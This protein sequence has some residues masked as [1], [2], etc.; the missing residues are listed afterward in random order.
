MSRSCTLGLA[1][2]AGVVVLAYGNSL[3]GS[4]HYDDFH[5][6]A[7]NPHIRCL[8]NLPGFFA[9]PGMFSADP[10]KAMYRPLL[11]V[12]YAFNYAFNKQLGLDGYDV[13]SFH[14][15]NVGLHLLGAVLVWQLGRQTGAGDRGALLAGLLF[16]LHPLATEPVNYLSSRSESLGAVL[17]LAGFLGFVRR[18][19]GNGVDWPRYALGLLAFAG[20]LLSKSVGIVLPLMLLLYEGLLAGPRKCRGPGMILKLHGPF[21]LV[22]LAYLVTV[23]NF[24]A[25]AGW[26][27]PVRSLDV[28]LWTQLKAAVYYLKLGLVPVGL[29]VEHQFFEAAAFWQVPVLASGLVLASLVATGWGGISR[30]DG[31]WLAWVVVTLAPSS[32]IPLNVLVNEHRLYL[33]MAGLAVAAGAR[34]ASVER[35]NRMKGAV[36][37][38]LLALGILTWQR[39]RVWQDELS[40]WQDAVAKGPL[41]P[42]AHVH[43]GNARRQG[44]QPGAARAA[45]ET[46]LQLEPDHRAARTNLGNLYY[47]A[48]VKSRA[49]TSQSRDHLL[50]AAAHYEQVLAVDSTYKEALNNLGSVYLLLG[51]EEAAVRVYRRA[52]AAYPH[53]GTAYFNL[54]QLRARQGVPTE[55]IAL[56]R[57]ALELQPD[58]ETC[59]ELGNVYAGQGELARAATA[60]RQ[61]GQLDRGNPGYLYNL[62]EVL[63]VLGEQ[64]LASGDRPRG[65]GMWEEAR[66]CFRQVAILAPGY[67]RVELRLAQLEER[68]P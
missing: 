21:W 45:F 6:M 24:L 38:L 51:R 15:V 23:W 36:L 40:L 47:E 58:A 43:L 68:L 26:G 56:Y 61:A 3:Q 29:N 14:L 65:I 44:G 10:E 2:L 13:R 8:G 12:T 42:R 9:D 19:Q 41:M 66:Q 52:I 22:G 39:N 49:D 48:G 35:S 5:S 67:R 18:R 4:L 62:G 16:A 53:F 17:F 59:F 64:A 28:Q 63:L 37:A 33:P 11:L 55:A 34:W 31:F 1:A 27:R 50:R 32:L 25:R 60:Y 54:G 46:A 30:R 57:Q 7:Q 20:A